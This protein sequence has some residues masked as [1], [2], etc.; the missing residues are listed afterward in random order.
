MKLLVMVDNECGSK[1]IRLWEEHSAL[2]TRKTP[3][4][5]HRTNLL[6]RN[7]NV[8]LYEIPV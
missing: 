3:A 4:K 6:H 5:L 8:L 7:A 1:S 2:A